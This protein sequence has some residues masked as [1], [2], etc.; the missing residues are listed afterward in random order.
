MVSQ[1]GLITWYSGSVFS[2]GPVAKKGKPTTPAQ[3][4]KRRLAIAKK[5]GRLDLSTRI[6][7]ILQQAPA[8]DS[9]ANVFLTVS[10]AEDTS[11]V[12]KPRDEFQAAV[13]EAKIAA[14][15]RLQE[16]GEN[17]V[18]YKLEAIPN[19]AFDIRGDLYCTYTAF[20]PLRTD[21]A[22]AMPQSYQ[23]Y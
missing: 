4:V 23:N 19:A 10:A 8:D 12:E 14:R 2:Q 18:E 20:T 15:R 9:D 6:N 16:E 1:R 3:K 17:A 13:L 5:T 22:L 7:R 11:V 21:G